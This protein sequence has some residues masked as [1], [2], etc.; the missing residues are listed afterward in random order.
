M[1]YKVQDCFYENINPTPFIITSAN[2]KPLY[3][4]DNDFCKVVPGPPNNCTISL[5]NIK[6][7][8]IKNNA[9]QIIGGPGAIEPT[10]TIGEGR[11]CEE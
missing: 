1:I 6:N 4:K 9:N 5:N 3:I 7:S 8:E 10:N 11:E 2:V